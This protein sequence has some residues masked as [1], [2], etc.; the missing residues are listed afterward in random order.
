LKDL[1]LAAIGHD[2]RTPLGAITLGS[3]IIQRDQA[4]AATHPAHIEHARKIERAAKRMAGIIEDVLDLTR[5]QFMGGIELSPR[6]ANLGDLCRA[7]V[8][9]C[10]LGHPG[11]GIRLELSGDLA[12]HWD[13]GRLGRVLSNL[14]GNALE[15][16]AGSPIGVRATDLGDQLTLEVHSSAPIDPALL[17][18]LFD[19]FRR[20]EE[21]RKGL[22]LGLYIVRE[23]VRAHGG[24]VQV[25]STSTEGTTFAVTLPRGMPG[26]QHGTGPLES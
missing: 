21:G 8:E 4:V 23:I 22:G 25:T 11:S 16:G 6:P 15:H 20:G 14:I 7:V 9:E 26:S 1:F 2:L 13:P 19:P 10:R 3:Q 5:D 17:P 24:S 18:V 12:G